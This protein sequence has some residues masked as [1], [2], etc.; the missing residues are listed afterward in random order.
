MLL[1][2]FF[3][4]LAGVITVLSPCVLPVLPILLAAGAGQGRLRPLGIILGIILSFTFF[5]LSLAIII[6][7][8]GLS[9]DA[10]RYV[11]IGLIV[12]FALVMIFPKLSIWFEQTT[13]RIGKLGSHIQ[14][15]TYRGSGFWSGFTLGIAL[16]LIWTPCAGPILATV[17]TLVALKAITLSTILI[18]F[19]YSFGSALPMFGIVYGSSKLTTILTG[20]SAYSVHIRKLF[21]I[22]MLIGAA[23]IAF[24]FD[25]VLQQF[26][27]Q[28]FP[29]ITIE[30]S[31]IVRKNLDLLRKASS[32][33]FFDIMPGTRAPE[34]TGISTWINSQPLTME[35]L[36]GKVV[37]V[38]FWTYSCINCVR[39]LPYLKK[40]Y[41]NY[42]NKGFVIVG[43]HTPEFEF[44]KNATNVQEAIKRFNIIYP[45]ALDNEYKT[46]N[47]FN[48]RYW[49][50]HYLIDKEGIIRYIHFG[51]GEYVTTENQIRALLNLSLATEKEIVELAKAQTPEIYL[52]Y[53]R[54]TNY[55]PETTPQRNQVAMYDYK[56]TLGDD[57]VG[58]KGKWLITNEFIQS[59][60]NAAILNLS[61]MANRVYLVMTSE[62]EH[63]VKVLL[64]G[65]PL[66]EKYFTTDMNANGEL[67]IKESRMYT[68]LDLKGDYGRH[69]LTLQ[70]PE[71]VCLYAFTFGSED[72]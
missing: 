33:N 34:F 6:R 5:T 20:L 8:T 66:P 22:C 46:W 19:A 21:G 45:V 55:S 16:G 25:I 4:F 9:A 67:M 58:L 39:T 72:K 27:A 15:S 17:T 2:L 56:T 41:A 60:D 52:G 63:K 48:N 14:T 31:S 29:I 70:V 69:I 71:N 44:E 23:T 1:L 37:L 28:Y 13:A 59:K 32:M 64:D 12:C 62:Q 50:A 7:A 35:Q 36:R 38:D 54:G 24:H 43:V 65:N 49:P 42:I 57:Q 61:F 26:T 47:N 10:L 3:A 68:I 40:W 30:N 18:T 11:A 51:E 53:S